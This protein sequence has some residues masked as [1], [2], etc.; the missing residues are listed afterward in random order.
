[1]NCCTE[2][3]DALVA[4]GPDVLEPPFREDHALAADDAARLRVVVDQ[5][6]SLTDVSALAWHEKLAV[7]SARSLER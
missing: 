2:L 4:G 1:M 3:L 6:A 5:V 7:S